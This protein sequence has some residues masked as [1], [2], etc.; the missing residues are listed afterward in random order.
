MGAF[1]GRGRSD[2]TRCPAGTS[3]RLLATAPPGGRYVDLVPADFERAFVLDAA[4][5]EVFPIDATSPG[6]RERRPTAG[7]GWSEHGDRR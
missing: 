7:R 5:R 3:A 4:R 2:R 1:A 6:E